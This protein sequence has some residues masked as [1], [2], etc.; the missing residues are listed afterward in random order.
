MVW[1]GVVGGMKPGCGLV[2]S[3]SSFCFFPCGSRASVC[4][5]WAP[6]GGGSP[7]PRRL[8]GQR[9]PACSGACAQSDAGGPAWQRGADHRV[10]VTRSLS[11]CLSVCCEL[12]VVWGS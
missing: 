6:D 8:S 1:C 5:G 4:A 3:S 9:W 2:S 10:R 12:H 11:V 7:L